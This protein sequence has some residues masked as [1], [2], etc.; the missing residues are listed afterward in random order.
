MG[1]FTAVDR[2]KSTLPRKTLTWVSQ[3]EIKAAKMGPGLEEAAGVKGEQ[4]SEEGW[5]EQTGRASERLLWLAA[6]DLGDDEF[7]PEAS[8]EG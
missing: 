1:I 8:N 2:K 7:S 6:A 5:R 4:G 3:L